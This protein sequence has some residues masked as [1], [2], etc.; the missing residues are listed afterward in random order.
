[1]PGLT[2]RQVGE[3][4]RLAGSDHNGG[5]RSDDTE[6]K[7]RPR[8]SLQGGAQTGGGPD[9][10][11]GQHPSNGWITNGHDGKQ[12]PAARHPRVLAGAGECRA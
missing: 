6:V 9:H 10:L 12:F 5:E 11:T 3:T 2:I 7:D 8:H 1:M 4:G